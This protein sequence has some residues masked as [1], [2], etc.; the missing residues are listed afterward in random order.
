MR[1]CLICAHLAPKLSVTKRQADAFPG[2]CSQK[3]TD[4]CGIKLIRVANPGATPEHHSV[5]W[6]CG[7][8]P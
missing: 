6:L 2:K 8:D 3:V 1:M 7:V 5:V 4:V